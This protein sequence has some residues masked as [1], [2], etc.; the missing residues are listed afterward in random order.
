MNTKLLSLASG[1]VALF[2]SVSSWAP[3][4]VISTH[5]DNMQYFNSWPEIAV[6]A[7]GNSYVTWFGSDGNDQEIYWVE[8]NTEGIP[9]QVQKISVHPDNIINNDWYPQIA[10]DTRG[11]S[12]V[13]WHCFYEDN[14]DIYWVKITS[15][16]ELGTVQKIS[17]H[18]NCMKC[19]NWYPQIAVDSE[20][21]SYVV[22]HGSDGH[23]SDVYWTKIDTSGSQGMVQK[24]STHPDNITHDDLNP[25]VAVDA[26]GNSHV[27][28]HGCD[29][30][31]CWDEPGDFEIYWVKISAEGTPGLVEKIPATSPEN[32]HPS[33]EIP[34]IAVDKSENSCIVWSGTDEMSYN[35]YWIRIDASGTLGKIQ[36]ISTHSREVD[37]DDQYPQIAVD[38]TGNSYITWESFDGDNS[39]ICWVTIDAPGTLGEIQMIS[40]YMGS[41]TFDDSAPCIVVDASGNSY[42]TWSSYNREIAEQFD[43][44]IYWIKIDAEG[45]LGRVQKVPSHP[46]SRHFDWNSRIAVDARGN[47]YITWEGEDTSGN[48]HIFFTARLLNSIPT[49]IVV[50]SIIVIIVLTATLA[51]IV[52]RRCVK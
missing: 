3:V 29:K 47:S 26:S 4:V 21:N 46:D 31:S 30:E 10:V 37:Y 25:R 1:V 15:S 40:D 28:W 52:R 8:V 5:E 32:I 38:S 39:D 35:I 6:D 33:N 23:D 41:A 22:W 48:S 11:N 13:V 44:R 2:L 16:G 18:S 27:I 12:Y 49:K 9:G 24:I 20:G 34:Q 17:N 43:Q 19:R 36:K 14:C 50:T 45:N 7:V 42:V 51:I